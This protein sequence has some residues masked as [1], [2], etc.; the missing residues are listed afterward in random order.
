MSVDESDWGRRGKGLMRMERCCGISGVRQLT[1][2]KK[3][4]NGAVVVQGRRRE[5]S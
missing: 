5:G 4:D 3:G 1:G 2:G